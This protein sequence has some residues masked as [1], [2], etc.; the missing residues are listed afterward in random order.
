MPCRKDYPATLLGL[1]FKPIDFD[2]FLRVD[3]V[4]ATLRNSTKNL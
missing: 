3:I 2:Q 1:K 4:Y